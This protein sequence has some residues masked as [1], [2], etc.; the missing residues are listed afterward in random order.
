M[1]ADDRPNSQRSFS[2]GGVSFMVRQEM[3]SMFLSKKYLIYLNVLEYAD[4]LGNR[5]K[6][7]ALDNPVE[8]VSADFP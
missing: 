4:K 1:Y 2:D 3:S 7:A 5:Q 8:P 6:P